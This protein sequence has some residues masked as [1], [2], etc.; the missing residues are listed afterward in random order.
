MA[1]RPKDPSVGS[2]SPQ[3]GDDNP[4]WYKPVMFGLMLAGL[5]WILAYYISGGQLVISAVGSWNIAIGFG[6]MF[7]GF[8]MTTRWK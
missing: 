2:L 7:V 3:A 6:V 1:K 4:A 8:L 5:V